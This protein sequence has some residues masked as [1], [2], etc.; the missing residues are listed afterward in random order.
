MHTGSRMSYDVFVEGYRTTGE[1]RRLLRT[2]PDNAIIG[3]RQPYSSRTG[4]RTFPITEPSLPEVITRLTA[5]VLM[6]DHGN[7][8]NYTFPGIIR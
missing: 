4:K 6:F 1:L 8:C 3:A 2:K 7:N 5:I